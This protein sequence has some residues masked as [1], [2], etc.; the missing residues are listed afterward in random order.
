MVDY[1]YEFN[2]AA[3]GVYAIL[4]VLYFLRTNYPSTTNKL[5]ITLVIVDLAAA[6]LDL[7]TIYTITN[8]D[9]VPLWFNWAVNMAYLWVFNGCAILFSVYIIYITKQNNIPK[10]DRIMCI[11]LTAVDSLLIFTTPLTKLRQHRTTP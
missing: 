9:K 3:C 8:P 2:I 5:Y 10:R 1:I 6:V 7:I 11:A 4:L